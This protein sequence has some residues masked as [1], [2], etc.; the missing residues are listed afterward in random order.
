MPEENKNEL[1]DVIAT[2][3]ISI[4]E[5]E[6]Q[7]NSRGDKKH[8]SYRNRKNIEW[9]IIYVTGYGLVSKTL[10]DG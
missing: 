4:T 8:I 7:K 1:Y 9:A 5:N 2:A 10:N 6:K 3:I